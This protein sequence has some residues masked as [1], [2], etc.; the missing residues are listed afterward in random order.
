[1]KK[2]SI[3]FL[4]LLLIGS[5][6]V[7][8]GLSRSRQQRLEEWKNRWDSA[9]Q[10]N[11]LEQAHTLLE[12]SRIVRKEDPEYLE[13]RREEL[14]WVETRVNWRRLIEES[15]VEIP[16]GSF[17]MGNDWDGLNPEKNDEIPVHTV[18]L[19][20]FRMME[21]EVTNSMALALLEF[22]P[23]DW[24][25]ENS[26]VV[27]RRSGLVLLDPEARH[28]GIRLSENLL[29]YSEEKADHPVNEIT[30]YGSIFLCNLMSRIYGLTEAYD[31]ET[32]ELNHRGGFRLP[33]EAE[34]EWAA[35]GGRVE[36][37]SGGEIPEELAW[38]FPNSGQTTQPVGFKKP[39][40]FGL[41]DMSGNVYEWCQ[42]WYAH[43]YYGVSP[44]KNPQGPEQGIS[45]VIRGGSYSDR[46]FALRVSFRFFRP[47]RAEQGYLGFRPVL[48]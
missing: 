11:N 22:Y 20:S 14:Q 39:N 31:M 32:L 42:D 38:Y 6:V 13:N 33:T 5:L 2:L 47:P 1:M 45:R 12:E 21:T 19:D 43:D 25:L 27:H 9:L 35:G 3:L 8:T 34:W 48:P 29:T 7:L 18:T 10:E 26:R 17:S 16:G 24:F 15:L 46:A 41:Y 4:A 28:S 40:S 37:Y 23:E 30:W 44:S 36:R